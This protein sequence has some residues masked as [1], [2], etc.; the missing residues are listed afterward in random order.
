MGLDQIR[1]AARASTLRARAIERIVCSDEFGEAY[2]KSQKGLDLIIKLG[3]PDDL[4]Q[5]IREQ[6]CNGIE[7]LPY[8]KLRELA[9]ANQIP[10][11]S[12]MNK[13]ELLR[14]LYASMDRRGDATGTDEA[15]SD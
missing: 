6:L 11:Y 10:R 14:A 5:W 7:D 13:D 9:S 4:R 8:G 3:K 15:T 2:Q 1:N 12:R